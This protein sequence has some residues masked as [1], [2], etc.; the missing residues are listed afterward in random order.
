MTRGKTMDST[1]GRRRPSFRM[2][3][4]PAATK[5]AVATIMANGMERTTMTERYAPI[6]REP[7]LADISAPTSEQMKRK[8]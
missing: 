6:S 8:R 7:P 2:A 1:L 3:V 5:S 4:I